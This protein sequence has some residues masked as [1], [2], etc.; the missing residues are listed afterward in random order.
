MKRHGWYLGF[1]VVGILGILV[2]P[3]AGN[4]TS[5][6]MRSG[7]THFPT[8]SSKK[9]TGTST[10]PSKGTSPGGAV[11]AQ[12]RMVPLPLP[13]LVVEKLWVDTKGTLCV[14]LKNQGK[15]SISKKAFSRSVITFKAGG[16]VTRVFLTT[17]DRKA[18]LLTPGGT[19]VYKTGHRVSTV[20]ITVTVDANNAIREKNE[21]NNEKSITPRAPAVAVVGQPGAPA[22]GTSKPKPTTL[23][24]RKVP[25]AGGTV[26]K[27]GKRVY[28]SFNKTIRRVEIYHQG[29]RVDK[30]ELKGKKAYDIT[31]Y[32]KRY[33][34]GTLT[35][36]YYVPGGSKPHVLRERMSRFPVARVAAVSPK[37][38]PGKPSAS[39]RRK[40]IARRSP[41]T[42]QRGEMPRGD[43]AAL[44]KQVGGTTP[45]GGRPLSLFPV[46]FHVVRPSEGDVVYAGWNYTIQWGWNV[47]SAFISRDWKVGIYLWQ[48]GRQI[49]RLGVVSS[50]HTEYLW[51]HTRTASLQ[52]GE[53]YQI[54]LVFSPDGTE[55]HESYETAMGCDFTVARPTL[56]VGYIGG[57]ITWHVLAPDGLKS[58][59]ATITLYYRLNGEETWHEIGRAYLLDERYEWTPPPVTRAR[60]LWIKARWSHQ[61]VAST[62]YYTTTEVTDGPILWGPT[63]TVARLMPN[64]PPLYGT[65]TLPSDFS[66]DPLVLGPSNCWGEVDVS[67][68]FGHPA[69]TTAAPTLAVDLRYPSG[70]D[71]RL[72]ALTFYDSYYDSPL[73]IRT[74]GGRYITDGVVEN[75]EGGRYLLWTTSGREGSRKAAAGLLVT[76][77]GRGASCLLNS[78]NYATDADSFP[79]YH[80]G[81][82]P[83]PPWREVIDVRA[84]SCALTRY[85]TR[86]EG[87]GSDW[88]NLSFGWTGP[89]RR[90]DLTYTGPHTTLL[91]RTPSGGFLCGESVTIHTPEEG[92]YHVWIGLEEPDST[93]HGVFEIAPTFD[94]DE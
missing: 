61:A 38:T 83:G 86:W 44:K 14:K 49:A 28:L 33:P 37:G 3:L 18:A 82:V 36:R 39:Q 17:A 70:S 76:R 77:A 50:S 2:A 45:A 65:K 53:H 72:P 29:K 90:L 56:S 27:R 69:Y 88:S 16:K 7:T 43:K 9:H 10:G 93:S 1:L 79:T 54:R 66:P 63:G 5:T 51:P 40:L 62:D 32:A 73:L 91:V 4:T 12:K 48:N 26:Q 89:A 59:G 35:F 94:E 6:M 41:V 71:T 78:H 80:R 57:F 60:T 75:P 92:H 74:P 47:D 21:K 31:A 64:A 84:G 46:F 22:S 23:T 11:K 13:D 34:T 24:R 8:A 19:A 20:K 52:P 67:D 55:A 30:G 87:Y 85:C 81:Y 58:R 68:R 25:A 15:G 42:E